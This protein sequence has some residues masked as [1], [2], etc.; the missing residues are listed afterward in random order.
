M[1]CPACGNFNIYQRGDHQVCAACDEVLPPPLPPI[2][3]PKPASK[4]KPFMAL[5]V[6]I[7]AVT[8]LVMAFAVFI[9][10][11]TAVNGW[12]Y[13]IVVAPAVVLFVLLSMAALDLF[14]I[15]LSQ[16]ESL[17]TIIELLKKKS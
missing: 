14:R 10:A 9:F 4:K 3:V 2:V 5:R 6:Y 8:F 17:R 1:P 15:Q 12:E 11:G 13:V 7:N 16:E